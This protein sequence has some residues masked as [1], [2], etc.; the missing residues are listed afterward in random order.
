MAVQPFLEP[1]QV[2]AVRGVKPIGMVIA[3]EITV[4]PSRLDGRVATPPVNRRACEV[5]GPY[6]VAEKGAMFLRQRCP[7]A[8][9]VA[10]VEDDAL[11]RE[12]AAVDE[13]LRP[14]MKD[15]GWRQ[16]VPRTGDDSPLQPLVDRR[17]V[18]TARDAD[19]AE[20]RHQ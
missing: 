17:P 7:K 9:E 3:A 11:Q 5:V 10:P 14:G 13:Y 6:G 15:I 1:R 20:Q 18:E 12:P 19:T 8:V 16:P 4:D 2:G